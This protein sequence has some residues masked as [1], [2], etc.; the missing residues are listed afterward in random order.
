V[1]KE[2]GPFTP[3][4]CGCFVK[5]SETIMKQLRDN[6]FVLI[7]VIMV[8]AVIALEMF[9]LASI[10]NTMQFQSNTAYLRACERNLVASGLAWAK[11]NI[12]DKGRET[13]DKMIQLDV[14]EMDIRDAALEVTISM[15]SDKGAQV[16]IST[17]CSRGR[18]TLRADDQYKIE[19]Y[20]KQETTL[21][22]RKSP[23]G[24]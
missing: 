21:R 13:F 16:R 10:A 14:T 9:V 2:N 18:Q 20:D 11:Q 17:S 1:E 15:P 7:L 22:A 4:F 8:M 24:H 19:L 3:V 12:Q 6:G 5:G 23:A